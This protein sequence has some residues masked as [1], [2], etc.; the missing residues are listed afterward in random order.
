MK[1]NF[2][3]VGDYA[4]DVQDIMNKESGISL[5][6]IKPDINQDRID[7]IVNRISESKDF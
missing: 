3:I 4:R 5:K 6:A 7:G 2:D 1:R